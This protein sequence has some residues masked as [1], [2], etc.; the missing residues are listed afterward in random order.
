MRDRL[1]KNRIYGEWVAVIDSAEGLPPNLAGVVFAD[2]AIGD[3]LRP[4][5]GCLVNQTGEVL[6]TRGVL[7][8]SSSFMADWSASEDPLVKAPL[9]VIWFDDLLSNFKRS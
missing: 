1:T 8:G 5:G 9:G 4:L 7:E 6:Q 2:Q 3:T